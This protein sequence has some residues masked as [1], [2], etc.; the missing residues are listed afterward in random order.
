MPL[1]MIHAASAR[2]IGVLSR[3]RRMRGYFRPRGQFLLYDCSIEYNLCPL[4]SAL[5]RMAPRPLGSL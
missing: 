5:L 1:I 4:T 3:G 2:N